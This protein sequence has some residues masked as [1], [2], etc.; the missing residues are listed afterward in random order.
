MKYIYEFVPRFSDFDM[1]GIVHHSCYLKYIEEARICAF[2]KVFNIGMK[3][4]LEQH[5][6]VVVS[7]VSMKYLKMIHTRKSYQIELEL[8]FESG[9][10]I[11]THFR[12]IEGEEVFVKGTMK[13][14]FVNKQGGLL[15]AYP[16]FVKESLRKI[17]N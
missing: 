12:V 16:E 9:V 7:D 6:N 1:L 13:L 15:L 4:F 14:C 5:S 2:E 17:Q 10:Y 3:L 8:N 11:F